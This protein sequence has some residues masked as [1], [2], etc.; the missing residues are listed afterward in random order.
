[1][2]AGSVQVQGET[3]LEVFG[4]GMEETEETRGV[5]ATAT[6]S[7]SGKEEGGVLSMS[8]DSSDTA[9]ASPGVN[10]MGCVS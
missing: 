3:V 10:A 8:S 2:R 5:G 7:G 6:G 9:S 1:M 4:V